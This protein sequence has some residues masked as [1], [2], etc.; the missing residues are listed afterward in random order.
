MKKALSLILALMLC[1]S[2]CDCGENNS[3]GKDDPAADTIE[4]NSTV[5]SVEELTAQAIP[6]TKDDING[7]MSNKAIAASFVDNVYSFEGTVFSIETDHV[8]LEFYIKD[9]SGT[10]I[11]NYA[12]LCAKVYLPVDELVELQKGQRIQVAGKVSSASN[13]EIIFEIA[14]IEQYYEVTGTLRGQNHSYEGSYNFQVGNSSVYELV[15]FAD[16][17]DLNGINTDGDQITISTIM[18]GK[19]SGMM[20]MYDYVDATIVN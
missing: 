19:S 12:V 14:A 8:I 11:T 17:V 9:D 7:A 2:L 10:L 3:T 1:L 5:I 15:Y 20:F 16:G 18:L 4:E 6:F 13:N